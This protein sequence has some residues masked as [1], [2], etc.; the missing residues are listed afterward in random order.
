MAGPTFTVGNATITRIDDFD[1]AKLPA[2]GL[3]PDWDAN[4]IGD[5]PDAVPSGTFD[6]D[7]GTVPLPVHSWLIR[8]GVR[9]I[10]VDT[11]AGN[12]RSGHIRRG[13][14]G[15]IRRSCRGWPSKASLRRTSPMSC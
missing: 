3:L 10:L 7:E 13:S 6:A 11:G 1:E 15:L 12:P 9:T 4:W 2:Q 14:T 8:D 5:H